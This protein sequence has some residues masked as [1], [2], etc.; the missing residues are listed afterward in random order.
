MKAMKTISS[1]FWFISRTTLTMIK[2]NHLVA[3]R[4][5]KITI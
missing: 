1:S 4:N 3:L 5:E 2:L